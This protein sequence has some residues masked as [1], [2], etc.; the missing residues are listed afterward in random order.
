MD[1][2]VKIFNYIFPNICKTELVTFVHTT[3]DMPAAAALS[4]KQ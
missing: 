4:Q 2:T 3:P 1:L